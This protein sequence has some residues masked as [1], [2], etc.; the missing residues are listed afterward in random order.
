[1]AETALVYL[2]GLMLFL[3]H[4]IHFKRREGGLSWKYFSIEKKN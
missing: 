4:A 3:K 1:M 2:G